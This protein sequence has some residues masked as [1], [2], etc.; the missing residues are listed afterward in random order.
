LLLLGGG[1]SLSLSTIRGCSFGG[2][3]LFPPFCA[4]APPIGISP[5]ITAI[6]IDLT[7]FIFLPASSRFLRF[8]GEAESFYAFRFSN[9]NAKPGC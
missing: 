8:E 4:K 1:L 7:C 9:I 2:R 3:L 6:K 5:I